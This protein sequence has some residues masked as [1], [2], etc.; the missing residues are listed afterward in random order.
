MCRWWLIVLVTIVGLVGPAIAQEE[1]EE[2]DPAQVAIGERLFLETRFAQFAAAQGGDV[3]APFPIGDPVVQQLVTMTGSIPSPFA[4]QS[5]N[6]RS[7]HLVDDVKDTPGGGNRSYADFARQS[8]IP[9]REDGRTTTPRNSPS[10]VNASLSRGRP[11]FLHFD[12]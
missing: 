11:F 5:M 2:A 12:G 8:P 7:C 6:C 4:G 10:L 9:L 1:E 3:N